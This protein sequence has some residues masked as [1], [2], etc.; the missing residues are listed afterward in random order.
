MAF[1]SE[2]QHMRQRLKYIYSTLFLLFSII[3]VANL[4]FYL[5]MLFVISCLYVM[6][7]RVVYKETSS[8]LYQ[9][10]PAMSFMLLFIIMVGIGCAILFD[11][12]DNFSLRTA[13]CMPLGA[14][15]FACGVLFASRWKGFAAKQEISQLYAKEIR[16]DDEDEHVLLVI[17]ASGFIVSLLFTLYYYSMGGGMPLREAAISF[18]IGD[19]EVGREA[20]RSGRMSTTFY[21]ASTYGGQGYF[22]QFRIVAL[23]FFS[24][25]AYIVFKI[26]KSLRWAFVS[27]GSIFITAIML[28]GT[29]QRQ[30]VMF[31]FVMLYI[32]NALVKPTSVLKS[33]MKFLAV[34]FVLYLGTTYVLGRITGTG[35]FSGDIVKILK[36]QTYQRL[37]IANAET[38]DFVIKYFNNVEPYRLGSTWY[39]DFI[40][41]LPGPDSSFS[42]EIYEKFYGGLGSASPMSFS[43]MY[44]NFGFVGVVIFSVLMGFLFQLTYIWYVRRPERD[45]VATAYFVMLTASLIKT[46]IGGMLGFIDGGLLGSFMI[47]IAIKYA[48]SQVRSVNYYRIKGCV[49]D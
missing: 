6:A 49:Y 13:I 35:S 20:V 24:I 32:A 28:F 5:Q 42:S 27:Y 40:A 18:V 9:L 15:V 38:T 1:D 10:S 36:E 21:D 11:P 22:D 7:A 30:P 12:E 43:E 33:G 39:N 47:Y 3:A 2:K 25:L 46:A 16:I 48:K 29:G 31:Y 19:V 17:F 41:L 44:A 14:L 23:P 34:F 8:S 4:P 26:K 45:A 37:F